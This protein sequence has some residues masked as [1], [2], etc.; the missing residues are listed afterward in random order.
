VTISAIN[1]SLWV[2]GVAL[3]IILVAMLFARRTARRFPVFSLLI[4][5][6]VVRSIL[7][8]ALFGHF[9]PDIYG[10]L[11]EFFS[12]TDLFLQLLLAG[13]I[14]LSILR[15]RSGWT[16]RRTARVAA[17]VV[18]SLAIAGA[19]AALLPAHG[20]IPIDRG[21]AFAAILMFIL[22]VAAS[23]T[24]FEG[25]PRRIA[26]GFALYGATGILA[27]ELRNFAALHHNTGVIVASS[28][29]QAGIYIAILLYWLFALEADAAPGRAT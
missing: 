11:Y 8:F 25:T 24:R 7:L 5:F 15:L 4:I 26:G 16:L 2:T 22:F 14:T 27:S 29:T 6:Y 1:L 9:A 12:W 23:F 28:Y 10:R 18:L 21:S 19:V 3:Q 13:E 17:S 20:R